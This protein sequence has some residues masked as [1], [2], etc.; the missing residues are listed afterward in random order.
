MYVKF[1]RQKLSV[2]LCYFLVFTVCKY[3]IAIMTVIKY[4]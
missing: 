1:Q 2:F 3:S 4:C